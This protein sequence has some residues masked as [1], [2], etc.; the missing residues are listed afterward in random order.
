MGVRAADCGRAGRGDP[1]RVRVPGTGCAGVPPGIWAGVGVRGGDGGVEHGIF[2]GLLEGECGG[3]GEREG[4]VEY[5]L[6]GSWSAMGLGLMKVGARG[7]SKTAAQIL[8]RPLLGSPTNELL[9]VFNG[10]F[11]TLFDSAPCPR[12]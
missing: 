5:A 2:L 11:S 6:R 4:E 12:T 8:L 10:G 3:E 9:I 1:S 7:V